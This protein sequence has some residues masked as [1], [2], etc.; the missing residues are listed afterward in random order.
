[1]VYV[2]CR[3]VSYLLNISWKACSAPSPVLTV[4][5]RL[6]SETSYCLELNTALDLLP[7]Y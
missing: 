6:L 7:N 5:H 4:T 2:E 3:V 1:M